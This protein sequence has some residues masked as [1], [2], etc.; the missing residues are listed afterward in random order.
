MNKYL[1]LYLCLIGF[2]SKGQQNCSIYTDSSC[3]RACKLATLAGTYPQGS[4]SSQECLDS[5]IR[6][7]PTMADAWRELSVPYLKR[8]DFVT[9]RKYIDKAVALQPARF[10]DIRGWC[11]FKFLRDYEGALEDLHKF[12]SLSH[13]LSKHTGDGAYSLNIIMALCERELGNYANAAYYFSQGID[14]TR[15][16]FI[17]L[18]DYL[19]R[20]VLKLRQQDYT[21]ALSDLALQEKLCKNYVE[22]SYYKGIAYRSLGKHTQAKKQFKNAARLYKEGFHLTDVYC[23]T[24]DTVYPSD[25]EEALEEY[26]HR[27]TI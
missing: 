17:G 9:W 22:T 1:L 12:D 13:F 21:G 5:A 6:L 26:N 3:N 2:T 10:L 27:K 19:H 14:S 24:L 7:C 16:D 23:E 15:K 20:A 4:R 11:R 25:V 8:G 18:F